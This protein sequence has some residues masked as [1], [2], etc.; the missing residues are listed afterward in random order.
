MSPSLD[1][2]SP[3]P[4]YHQLA[5]ALRYRIATGALAPGTVLPSLRDAARQWRVNLHTV[6]HAYA[7]LAAEGLVRTE[8]PRGTVI[9]G[10]LRPAGRGTGATPAALNRFLARMLREA[11]ARFGLAPEELCRSIARLAGSPAT[12]L[13]GAGPAGVVRSAELEPVHVVECSET[14]AADLAHQVSGA[15][16]VPAHGWSLERPGEPPAGP[17]VA[18]Y[19]HYND[20]RTRWPERFPALHFVAIHPD[21]DLA[22]RLARFRRRGRRTRALV[23]ERTAAMAANIA[24]DLRALLPDRLF[25][26]T[27]V[28]ASRPGAAFA[29]APAD[30]PMLFSPRAWGA[31][32]PAERADRRA[33][34]IR[35]LIEP[36][37]LVALGQELEWTARP[38]APGASA[39][40]TPAPRRRSRPASSA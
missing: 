3:V 19:F 22:S 36:K 7:A 1:P 31:L 30:A 17:V 28:V 29:S 23:V 37:D 15:W 4:L 26:L 38:A 39:H 18:T 13:A 9:L 8:V 14:Q 12:S 10:D 27:P 16:E 25:S 33:I 24:S 6:R 20:I 40:S 11:R 5:E 34:E 2:A 35:Y 21:P 32:T